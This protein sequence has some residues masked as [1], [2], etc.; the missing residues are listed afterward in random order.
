M[1]VKNTFEIKV[2]DAMGRVGILKTPHGTVQTP[3][4]MPVVNPQRMVVPAKKLSDFGIQMVMVNAYLLKKYFEAEVK[5]KGVHKFLGFSGPII[6]DSGAYQ[7]HLYGDIQVQPAEIVKFQEAIGSDI[8]VILDVPTGANMNY[9]GAKYTVEETLRR[10]REA[11]KIK[12]RE[13]IL[14]G[15]PVQGGHFLDLVEYSSKKVGKLDF[16]LHPIGEPVQFLVQY[17]F[18]K[19]IDIIMAAKK[20]LPIERPVHLFGAGH[21]IFFALAVALGCDLFDSAAYA[22][23]ARDGRYLTVEGTFRLDSL[24]E[25]PCSCPVCSNYSSQELK[26]AKNKEQLLAEHNLYATVS[27]IKK[28][29][30][31]IYENWLWELVEMRARSHPSLLQA[32]RHLKKYSRFIEQF[33]PVTK[34]SAFFYSGSESLFRSEI[35]RHVDRL[36][37]RYKPPEKAKILVLL[38]SSERRPF[39]TSFEHREYQ[40]TI[41]EATG[42][43]IDFIHECTYSAPF[44][45]IPREL[46][47]TYPLSQFEAPKILDL[48]SVEF[49]KQTLKNYLKRFRDKYLVIICHN[50]N[51]YWHNYIIKQCKRITAQIK[52]ELFVTSVTEKPTS[53]AALEKLK[54]AIKLAL[55]KVD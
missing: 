3:T 39:R 27:E 40:R 9:E 7:L 44:G 53:K 28:I 32:L 25:L 11:L 30:Q 20:N 51:L 18:D 6:S 37:N 34:K 5:E 14:W 24:Q 2:R 13:D 45:I 42:S 16:D 33:D 47:D 46:E 23:Y 1:D 22:L 4:L 15:G 10:A 43:K 21:P 52:R 26:K 35:I 8:G 54:I 12:E 38:P 50:D 17:Q 29:R 55:E 19:V 36:I 31:A 49:V 41:A 48:D